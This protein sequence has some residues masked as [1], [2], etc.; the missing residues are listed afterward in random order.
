LSAFDTGGHFGALETPDH[1]IGDIRR[2]FRIVRDL[3]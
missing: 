2:F 3:A 1:L